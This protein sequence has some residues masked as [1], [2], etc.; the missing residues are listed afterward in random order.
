MSEEPKH[1]G[2]GQSGGGISIRLMYLLVGLFAA[3]VICLMGHILNT[4]SRM[5]AKHMPLMHAAMQIKNESA[6]AHLWFEEMISGDITV[7]IGQIRKLQDSAAWHAQ[8]ML[9]GGERGECVIIPLDDVKLRNEIQTL[10]AKLAEFRDITNQRYETPEDSA[11]GS[12]IDQRCDAVFS[13]LMEEADHVKIELRRAIGTDLRKFRIVQI[14]LIIVCAALA[15]LVGISFDRFIRERVKNERLLRASKEEF[16]LLARFPSENPNP[17]LRVGKDG[18]IIFANESSRDLLEHLRTRMGKRLPEKWRKYAT[19]PFT[20]GTIREVEVKCADRVLSLTFAPVP[21]ADYV[22]IY[23]LDITKRRKAEEQVQS[24][25]KFPSENRSPV[26]RVSSD[27]ILLYANPASD[28]IISELGCKTGEIVPEDW[29]SNVAE[30]LASDTEKRV[31][32]K[33]EDRTFAFLVVPVT[34]AGYANIYGRDITERK[35]AEQERI[36]ANQQLRAANQQLVASEQQLRAANEQLTASEQQLRAANQQL[37]ASERQLRAAN[38]QLQADIAERKRAEQEAQ[39]AREY[40]E[41]IVETMCE[42]L[43]VL[44]GDLRVISVNDSFYNTFKVNLRTG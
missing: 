21:E 13:E 3:T 28:S 17:V 10:V 32:Y 1:R 31:E 33:H 16:R 35:K 29:R 5:A 12:E 43:I 6:L 24:L 9:D 7:N 20:P 19:E 22:N 40:A 39:H 27:G 18:T 2:N 37:T 26:L 41:S 14:V 11:I 15:V 44:D 4:G 25:A 34:D 42:P 36:S 30:V 8:A 38:Q 23:G